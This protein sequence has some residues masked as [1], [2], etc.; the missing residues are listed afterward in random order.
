M[1]DP[2]KPDQQE[3][4]YYSFLLLFV[5]FRCEGD[6]IGEHSFV[7]QAFSKFLTSSSDMEGHHEKLLKLLQAQTKVQK[8]NEHRENETV[9]P[10]DDDDDDDNAKGL[11]IAG[12]AVTAMN[13]VH[14]MAAHDKDDIPL[15]ERIKMLNSDQV[16]VFKNITDH[17]VHH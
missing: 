11:Q 14:D 5:P 3:D 10:E 6:L 4:Y 2:T 7:E 12:E 17:L 9:Y 8:I 1:Y 16:H 15:T 13:D